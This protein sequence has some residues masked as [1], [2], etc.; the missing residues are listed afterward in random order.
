MKRTGAVAFRSFGRSDNAHPPRTD[1]R[2]CEHCRPCIGPGMHAHPRPYSLRGVRRGADERRQG[3]VEAWPG[4]DDE[5]RL[6]RGREEPRHASGLGD[7]HHP[8]G[9]VPRLDAELVEPVNAAGRDPG[10]V[11]GRRADAPDVADPRD[12]LEATTAWR[13]GPRR[14]AEAGETSACARVRLPRPRS[15][16]P[17]RVGPPSPCRAIEL[18]AQR[19]RR[20]RPPASRPHP[21][22]PSRRT[23]SGS[24]RGSSWCRRGDRRSRR[25]PI[26][27][28]DV[29][30]LAQDAVVG[31]VCGEPAEDQRLGARRPRRP[32]RSG[33]T[34]SRSRRRRRRRSAG[35]SRRPRGPG[36]RPGG[37]GTRRGGPGRSSPRHRRGGQEA[38]RRVSSTRRRSAVP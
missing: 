22:R 20:S 5:R 25:T 35:V 38:S 37:P 24:R 9:A 2:T 23:S 8:G 28:A 26:A 3:V 11:E 16:A 29:A 21:R 30:L 15:A 18:V 14:V 13:R 10:E 27:R 1:G 31:A 36:T 12:Q 6:E 33:S 17:F 34:S 7:E 32:C 4:G 19:R